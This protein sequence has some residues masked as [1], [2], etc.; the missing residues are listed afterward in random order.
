MIDT[1]SLSV[2]CAHAERWMSN[3]S[4]SFKN[5]DWAALE[6]IKDLKKMLPEVTM[7]IYQHQED[8]D[9]LGVTARKFLDLFGVPE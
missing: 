8:N 7:L 6:K 4:L 5:E 1:Q 3:Y 2:I 9:E